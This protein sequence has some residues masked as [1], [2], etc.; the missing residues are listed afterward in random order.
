VTITINAHANANSAL[1]VIANTGAIAY[2]LHHTGSNAQGTTTN[3]VSFMVGS[4]PI[5]FFTVTP[6]RIVD[7]RNPAGPVGGPA[8]AA[9]VSRAFPI[10]GYCGVPA[11]ATSVS[12]NITVVDPAVM[13]NVA[14]YPAGITPPSTSTI[15]YNA[16][17]TRANNAVVLLNGGQ[18]EAICRQAS[19]ATDVVIDVNGY[20]Q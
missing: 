2:D 4:G 1:Q 7:T 17:T 3:N 18:L 12:L 11:T 6:C 15:N 13:G 8:L 14:L 16:G 19:G 10:A 5:D 9:G 20:F